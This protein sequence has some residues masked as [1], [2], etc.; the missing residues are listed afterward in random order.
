MYKESLASGRNAPPKHLLLIRRKVYK[1]VAAMWTR[2]FRWLKVLAR[3]NA[4]A[5][6]SESSLPNV[7]AGHKS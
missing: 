7:R 4:I 2:V 1:Q 6:T 5:F 3:C